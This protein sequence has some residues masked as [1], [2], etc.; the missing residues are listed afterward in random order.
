MMDPSDTKIVWAQMSH[1]FIIYLF[2]DF[3]PDPN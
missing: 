1:G 3:A 2:S